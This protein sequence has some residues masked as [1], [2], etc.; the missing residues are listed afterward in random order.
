MPKVYLYTDGSADAVTGEGAYAYAIV[1]EEGQCLQSEAVAVSGTTNNAMELKAV[2][3]GLKIIDSMQEVEVVSDSAYVVNCFLQKWYVKWRQNN[4]WGSA[5]P[6]KNLELWKDLL[7]L[8]E[9]FHYLTWTHVRGH[10]GNYWN[11]QV[12]RMCNAVRKKRNQ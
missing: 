7:A 9:T 12:D 10:Q 11:E 3:E 5:G 2:L 6:V 8:A 4:W 1:D